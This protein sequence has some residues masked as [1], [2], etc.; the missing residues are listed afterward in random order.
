MT[1]KTKGPILELGC[2]DYSTPIL[3][4]LADAMGERQFL[5][6]ASNEEWAS[7]FMDEVDLQLVDWKAWEPPKSSQEDGRWGLVFLDSE[8]AVRDRI[9]RLPALS[10]VCDV[11]VMH[12]A[13]IARKNPEWDE[14][15]RDYKE[16]HFYHRHIPWTA[17]LIP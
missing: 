3:Q 17:V 1:L 13:N 8:E 11:V 4:M 2:G 12:D 16:V 15:I 14:C 10:K 5:V 6:Q 7:R 9:K